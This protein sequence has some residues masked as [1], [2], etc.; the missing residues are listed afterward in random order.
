MSHL[1]D[2]IV[3][4]VPPTEEPITLAEARRFLRI[5][6]PGYPGDTSQD[7]LIR[8]YIT[9][10][11]RAIEDV[12]DRSIGVQ[13][14]MVAAE[15]FTHL[16]NCYTGASTYGIEL[17]Y[18]PIRSIVSIQYLT[19]DGQD[20]TVNPASY[21]LTEVPP[22]R[23]V[24]RPGYSWPSASMEPD[25][26]RVTYIAGMGP[27]A[28]GVFDQ[29]DTYADVYADNYSDSNLANLP[30]VVADRYTIHESLVIALR[31]LVGHYWI[32]RNAIIEGHI[33]AEV[34]LGVQSLLWP[35]RASVGI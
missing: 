20:L 23:I 35:N 30:A 2:N 33:V 25:S 15:S 21:R 24:L 4:V 27:A 31:M 19:S 11:R 17:P 32:N 18:G 10:A 16:A 5:D 29:P 7:D 14:L 12:I 1:S 34:P 3:V 6:V 8:S 13:T 28:R 22:Q 9:G 26:V